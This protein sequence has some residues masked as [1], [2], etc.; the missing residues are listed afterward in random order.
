MNWVVR[1][2][3]EATNTCFILLTR[4]DSVTRNCERYFS[5]DPTFSVDT[6][7]PMCWVCCWKMLA[8]NSVQLL[9]GFKNRSVWIPS[10]VGVPNL[11]CSR[12]V[13][14]KVLADVASKG[15]FSRKKSSSPFFKLSFYPV[16]DSENSIISCKTLH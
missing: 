1:I 11:Q 15:R 7:R 14:V 3:N 8:A 16:D 4:A 6:Y 12:Q 2:I 13:D 9:I 10:N 5:S